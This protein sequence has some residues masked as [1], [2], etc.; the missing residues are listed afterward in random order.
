M[1]TMNGHV[2]TFG[3]AVVLLELRCRRIIA[4]AAGMPDEVADAQLRSKP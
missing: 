3:I 2:R 4:T 1:Q